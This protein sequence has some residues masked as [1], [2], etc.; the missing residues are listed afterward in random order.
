MGFIIYS[1]L[2]ISTVIPLHINVSDSQQFYKL[3]V[4]VSYISLLLLGVHVGLHW[5]WTMSV[6]K[7]IF[8]IPQNSRILR[9]AAKCMVVLVLVYGCYTAY[10]I[11][12]FTRATS[13]TVSSDERQALELKKS[14]MDS[15]QSGDRSESAPDSTLAKSDQA[16]KDEASGQTKEQAMEQAVGSGGEK[17]VIIIDGQ[18]YP[19]VKSGKSAEGIKQKPVKIIEE[20][21]LEK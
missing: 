19:D 10:T 12:Y 6:F 9:Y 17:Q 20:N 16:K 15:L 2:A 5:D 1:G 4:A 21:G 7:K 11:N 14:M 3:H 18:Q 8:R 13:F